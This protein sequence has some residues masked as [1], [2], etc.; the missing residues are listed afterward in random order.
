IRHRS[1]REDQPGHPPPPGA[2]GRQQPAPH[3]AAHVAAAFAAW[4]PG[5]LL[6]RRDRHGRQPLPRRPQRRPHAHAVERRSQRGLLARR[7]PRP[8]HAS[9]RR[10]RLWLPGGQRGG[11]AARAGLAPQLDEAHH[12]GP[13]VVPRLR[14]RHADLPAAREPARA[15]LHARARGR[16]DPVRR[17][18]LALRAVRRARPLPLRGPHAGRAD[19]TGPLSEDRRPSLPPYPGSARLPVVRADLGADASAL[20]RPEWLSAQRWYGAN[21]RQLV[22]VQLAAAA[23]L[24]MP[25]SDLTAWLLVLHASFA[26]GPAV[27]YLVPAIA[28]GA[29]PLREPRDGEGAWRALATAIADGQV[30]NASAGSFRCEPAVAAGELLPNG[31]SSIADLAEQGLGVEQSNTSVTLG[32]GL[33]LKLYRRL[34]AGENPELEVGSFLE[35]VGCRVAPRIAGSLSYLVPDGNA[36]AAML[37]ERVPARSDAWRQLGALLAGDGGGP[38]GAIGA[39]REIGRVTAEVH[40]G[41][42]ARPKDLAFPL[43][44]A[45]PPEVGAWRE[46]ALNQLD[47]ARYA[48]EGANR[49]ALDRLASG[50][51]ARL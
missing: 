21:D 1:A 32:D 17:Q 15:R 43:R 41:L 33:F 24:A 4:D 7:R 38:K 18:P 37:Q 16:R 3:R 44:H 49:T 14:A 12:P 28:E 20:T 48:L 26:V 19:R 8:L 27:R 22:D 10:P 31:A 34:Q 11:P 6:R 39:A 40:R 25:R 5:H 42:A 50:I 13:E 47:Q 51:R 36:A 30:L 2:A 23:A 9:R 35:S 45:T 46:G 29:E